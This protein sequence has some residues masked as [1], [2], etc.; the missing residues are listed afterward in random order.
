MRGIRHQVR[1]PVMEELH[2]AKGDTRLVDIDPGVRQGHAVF[3]TRF[4]LQEETHTNKIAVLERIAHPFHLSG[5]RGPKQLPSSRDVSRREDII[6]T[7]RLA[8][9]FSARDAHS[10][11]HERGHRRIHTNLAAF[12]AHFMGNGLPH[13]AGA[14][15]WVEELLDEGGLDAFVREGTAKD[16]APR[17]KDRLRDR[18][19]FY[20]LRA[21]FSRKI[22]ARGT[23]PLL[24][25][26]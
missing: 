4:L 21:P 1:A 10:F 23:P 24:G 18:E 20:S 13:L 25:V 12:R 3:F 16:L 11:T 8:A 9:Y 19:A 15:R 2:A 17:V 6:S 22:L 7:D 5:R 26:C 14:K